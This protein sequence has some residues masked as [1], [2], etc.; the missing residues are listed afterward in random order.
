MEAD[1]KI[2][3]SYLSVAEIHVSSS[4]LRL[5]E[6]TLQK[7]NRQMLSKPMFCNNLIFVNHI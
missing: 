7:I 6:T 4:Y 5:K 2:L 1:V 3:K